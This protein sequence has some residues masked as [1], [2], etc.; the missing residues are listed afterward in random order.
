MIRFSRII[1]I[2]ISLFLFLSSNSLPR[3]PYTSSA[4]TFDTLL[5]STTTPPRAYSAANRYS[6]PPTNSEWTTKSSSRYTP[7]TTALSKYPSKCS[8]T[9]RR[10]DGNK[11]WKISPPAL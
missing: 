1:I 4:T 10:S 11:G 6:A 3:L 5:D 8:R 9:D 2:I 7:A